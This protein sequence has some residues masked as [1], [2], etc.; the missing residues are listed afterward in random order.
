MRSSTERDTTEMWHKNRL[1]YS[2]CVNQEF[3]YMH[4]QVLLYEIEH[5]S[6]QSH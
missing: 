2:P 3:C 1:S 6:E 4:K 5:L